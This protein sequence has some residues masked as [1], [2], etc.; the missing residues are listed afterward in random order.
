MC[1]TQGSKNK[2]G[3]NETCRLAPDQINHEYGDTDDD[4]QCGGG[5]EFMRSYQR[6]K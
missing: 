6:N 2:Q 1:T 4:D 3:F 5:V